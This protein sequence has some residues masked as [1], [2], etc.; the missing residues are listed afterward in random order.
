MG[1]EFLYITIYL[2]TVCNVLK[3]PLPKVKFGDTV[4]QLQ[5]WNITMRKSRQDKCCCHIYWYSGAPSLLKAIRLTHAQ[6][7][8]WKIKN[9]R[10]IAVCLFLITNEKSR[11]YAP[12]FSPTL[13]KFPLK[14]ILSQ[15]P[16]PSLGIRS[17][18][19]SYKLV[20][21]WA[22]HQSHFLC[23]YLTGLFWELSKGWL[24][25]CFENHKV[26]RCEKGKWCSQ[27]SLCRSHSA[28]HYRSREPPGISR[29]PRSSSLSRLRGCH[30]LCLSTGRWTQQQPFL[31]CGRKEGQNVLIGNCF[32]SSGK[33][34]CFERIVSRFGKKVTYVVIGDGRD[35]EIA[36]KQVTMVKKN[37]EIS[38]PSALICVY[39]GKE[40]KNLRRIWPDFSVPPWV[41]YLLGGKV[42]FIQK[43]F[44]FFWLGFLVFTEDIRLLNC[45][46]THWWQHK[47]S[48][49]QG[50][51]ET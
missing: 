49:V 2:K 24:E 17:L 30:L 34:S 25:N 41:I 32:L 6:D 13:K 10:E 35:E 16:E 38:G 8:F 5:L 45:L 44:F 31:W 29:C 36:A 20:W 33:E 1:F 42:T 21:I 51:A 11:P 43:L 19:T 9:W 27:F 48:V 12:T 18:K 22:S 28:S 37:V 39:F 7:C 46:I 14:N 40:K 47:K 26:Q 50:I 4:S 23:T 3:H 15:C